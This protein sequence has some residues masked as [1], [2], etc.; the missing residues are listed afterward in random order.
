ME[1]VRLGR[2]QPI[3][4]ASMP[5]ERLNEALDSA[6]AQRVFGRIVL[7]VAEPDA[8]ASATDMSPAAG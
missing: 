7:D 6:N 1:F 4:G 8:Y 2:V 5:L 3:V